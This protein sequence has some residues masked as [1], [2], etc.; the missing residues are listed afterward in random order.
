MSGKQRLE[1]NWIGK[2][3][4]T[5]LEP[6]ILIEDQGLSYESQDKQ[7]NHLNTLIHGD[8]LLVLKAVESD[9]AGKIQCIY[10]D[11]PYNTG[12]AFEHYDD[13]I[14]HSLW[15]SLLR[16]RLEICRELLSETGS[17]WISIDDNE[18]HYLKVLMDEIFGRNNF[19]TSVIWQKKYA[20]KADSKHLS[21]S[22][23]FIL[24][25]AKKIESVK[26][27]RIKKGGKQNSRYKNPD[28][29]PRGPWKPG[30]TLRNEVRD[31]AVFPIQAP[32]G[33]EFWPSDGTSW[34]YT[35]DKFQELISDNRIWFGKTGNSRPAIKRFL[36]EVDSTMPAQ[37]IW[38]YTEVGHND[39][40][41]KESKKLFGANLFGTPKPERLIARIIEL[42]TS[43]ED[44]VLDSF[45][46]SGTTGAVAH[47][48]NRKW[49]MIELGDHCH[50]HIA[51]RMKMVIDGKDEGGITAGANWQGGGGFRYFHLGPS[52]ITQDEWGREIIAPA[53]RQNTA[54][55]IEAMCKLHSYT[56]KPSDSHFWMHGQSTETDYIYVT[57]ESL[58]K[59]QIQYISEEVG[60]ERSL[61]ICCGSHRLKDTSQFPNVTVQKIPKSVLEKCEWGKDDYSLKIRNL[62]I[63]EDVP[64]AIPEADKEAVE[65]EKPRSGLITYSA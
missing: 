49:I 57:T 8:N 22:H 29:D 54:M 52:L 62:P 48:M 31:Y 28:D 5:R 51:P 43:P 6:R 15:L 9:Y 18:C 41:K 35:K 47:K 39:E 59:D 55:L 53:Y 50:T 36:S 38:P 27:N 7:T 58:T 2:E 24:V 42:S 13:G 20:P 40:S 4:R 65:A 45:A 1:L 11:P 30:D 61:L 16:E 23:D 60:D 25:Y 46:G 34:R 3:S 14:E 26:I 63:A 17:I 37:T 12:S 10:L 33:K 32:G 56:F 64:E 19:I 44:I 21:E